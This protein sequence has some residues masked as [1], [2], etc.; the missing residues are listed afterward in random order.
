[1]AFDKLTATQL[2]DALENGLVTESVMQTIMDSNRSIDLNLYGMTGSSS[3]SNSFHEWTLDRIAEPADNALVDGADITDNNSTYGVRVGN[4][5]QTS[6]GRLIVSYEADASDTIGR[7]SEL[8]YQQSKYALNLERSLQWMMYGNTA[9]VKGD[10][11]SGALVAARSAGLEAQLT[12]EVLVPGDI[13]TAPAWTTTL[14]GTADSV[15]QQV[16]SAGTI[17]GGGFDNFSTGIIPA[18]TYGTVTAGALTET[19]LRNVAQALWKNTGSK[20]TLTGLNSG[21]VN[22]LWSEYSF[23]S[24]ARVATQISDKG[25][26]SR[27]SRTAQGA[28]NVFVGD[29]GVIMFEPENIMPVADATSSSNTL[30]LVQP[31]YIEKSFMWGYKGERQAK[32]G[33]SDK[34]QLSVA[35]QINLLDAHRIGAVQ[36]IS[37]SEAMV[38]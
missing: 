23:T 31:G 11:D 3:H 29:F 38:F 6:G 35:W 15:V 36:G 28:N 18:W 24:S 8:A 16:N 30:F 19:T 1:M 2:Q 32:T 12:A 10:P 37:A 33:I 22:R 25:D 13:N 21:A 26:G 5:T 34:W 14:L 27:E 7:A 20:V 4:Y 9:S 17:T